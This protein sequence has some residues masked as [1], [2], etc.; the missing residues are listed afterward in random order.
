MLMSISFKAG[1]NSAFIKLLPEH[2]ER[3]GNEQ[4]TFQTAIWKDVGLFSSAVSGL[5]CDVLH[6]HTFK[7]KIKTESL[8]T[9]LFPPHVLSKDNDHVCGKLV[10]KSKSGMDNNRV[11]F[12]YV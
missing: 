6:R 7:L 11:G 9:Y 1:F 2:L 5:L 3:N 12:R 10:W 8:R 4:D